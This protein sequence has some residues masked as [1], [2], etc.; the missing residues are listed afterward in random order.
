MTRIER[1]RESVA[2]PVDADH[3]RQKSEAGWR[4]VALEWRREI[5]GEEQSETMIEEVPYGLRVAFDCLHLE[6]DPQERMI[7]I[8]MMDLIVQDH[9]ISQV[10]AELNYPDSLV[11][12]YVPAAPVQLNTSPTGLKLKIDGRDNLLQPYFLN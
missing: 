6:E 4:L 7:L 5:E 12:T 2:G 11:A 10:A 3:L 8:T 9:P 1:I